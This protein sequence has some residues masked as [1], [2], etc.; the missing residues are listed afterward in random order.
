[1]L[2]FPIYFI[3]HSTYIINCTHLQ[4]ISNNLIYTNSSRQTTDDILTFP[5]FPNHYYYYYQLLTPPSITLFAY[6]NYTT[7]V[8]VELLYILVSLTTLYTVLLIPIMLLSSILDVIS[9]ILLNENDTLV[10]ISFI[11]LFSLLI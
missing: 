6:H 9:V 7:K 3:S 10:I 5:L 1:M 8:T 4:Y 2:Y 11:S